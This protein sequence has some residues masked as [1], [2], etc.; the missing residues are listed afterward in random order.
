MSRDRRRPRPADPGHPARP[1]RSRRCSRS[2]SRS[3]RASPRT[4]A[5]TMGARA[6]GLR[7]R[8]RRLLRGRRTPSASPPAP[9]RSSLALRALGIGPGDE[10]IVPTNSFIAT[11]EAVSLAGRDAAAR[12]RR[13][14]RRT[15]SPP[16]PSQAAIGPRTRAVIPVHLMGSTV[17]IDPILEVARAAGLRVDRGRAPGARRPLPG[18]PRRHARRHR[19]LLLLPDQ[20]PR[21]R[22][23]TA[24]RVVTNDADARR[25]RPP[26][27]LARRAPA[28]PPPDRRHD[29][30]PR[31]APG[32]DPARQAAPARRLERRPP[33]RSARRCA[34][35]SR[36]RAVELPGARLRRR[37]TTSTTCSSCARERP[38][39][40][41]RAPRRSTA[42]RRAVHYP[43]PIHRTE[44]YADLG[45]GA[46]QP[47]R[48]RAARRADL[49]A[50]AV[51]DDVRRRGRRRSWPPSSRSSLSHAPRRRRAIRAADRS[52]A[53]RGS[54]V[55]GP[56]RAAPL[57][58]EARPR[59]GRAAPRSSASA[60]GTRRVSP[61]ASNP[62]YLDRPAVLGRVRVGRGARVRRSSGF[63]AQTPRRPPH[64]S[65]TRSSL[66]GSSRF[67]AIAFNAIG[68]SGRRGR[69]SRRRST[70]GSA[71]AGNAT[72][73]QRLAG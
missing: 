31:R 41:A 36:A 49:H 37:A 57:R 63:A 4:G 58:P 3:S 15:C 40:A 14:A 19:L 2:C 21:R 13:P 8:V 67:A 60:A 48:R 33:P 6:R 17:D 70:G 1:G 25:P 54:G 44:A 73:G 64:R 11:A 9:R 50:A 30:A 45:L 28:L 71:S 53:V 69:S 55:Y 59:R 65:S 68:E 20:E 39:R 27:A 18:P 66:A 7:G 51:P 12:R 23:A 24:A 56:V 32:R 46:G 72:E 29:R 62:P 22:G 52:R 35:A 43:F 10:V 61:A 16:R 38:R 47:A 34:P 5:F 26:A 42:S